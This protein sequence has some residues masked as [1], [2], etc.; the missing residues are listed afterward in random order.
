MTP[1]LNADHKRLLKILAKVARKGITRASAAE[2]DTKARGMRPDS[3]HRLTHATACSR[4]RDLLD[5]GLVV[6]V[7]K[8]RNKT[9]APAGLL[10]LPRFAPKIP[11]EQ[12]MRNAI[13][14]AHRT[15]NAA[16]R[17]MRAQ[18]HLVAVKECVRLVQNQLG[19]TTKQIMRRSA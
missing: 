4:F 13:R 9:G 11:P 10:Y 3:L 15:L 8:G 17:G 12:R 19:K 2:A 6:E 16:L 18:Q 1:R 5:A 7:G 14:E